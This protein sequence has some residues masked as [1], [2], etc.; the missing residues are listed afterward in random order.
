[1]KKYLLVCWIV[2]LPFLLV[3]QPKVIISELLY[4]PPYPNEGQHP[5]MHNGEF[6]SIYN[7]GHEA[8][9]VSGWRLV[10]DG[11]ASQFFTFPP[12]SIMEP[13]AKF[14]V[15]YRGSQTQN[16]VLSDLYEGFE[17]EANDR[18]WYHRAIILNNTGESLRL[19]REDGA[20][21]DSLWHSSAPM[22]ARNLVV[23]TPGNNC[24]SLQRTNVS[25]DVANGIISF[26]HSDWTA[27]KVALQ[28]YPHID[29]EL[30]ENGDPILAPP[31]STAHTFGYDLSGNRIRRTIRLSSPSS[32]PSHA[33]RPPE[34]N[35][36]EDEE[37]SELQDE[38]DFAF[39][40][41]ENFVFN[42]DDDD[43][44]MSSPETPD[45]DFV[46]E[47]IYTD[48]LN[49]SNVIIYPNPTKGALAVEIRNKNPQTQHQLT[50]LNF[51]GAVVFQRSD[52]ENYTQI[53]LSS[54]PKGVYFLRI[55]SQDRFI[56]W[57]IIKE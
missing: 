10:S 43:F 32:A 25:V 6:I 1:M 22:L 49:E 48:K 15:A 52:V 50:V 3:A 17:L 14:Y 57:K 45:N 44:P 28:E 37:K 11:G 55:S 23:G 9:D 38:N 19:Y 12:Q 41:E 24:L 20:T 18:K 36:E 16:F 51:N 56:T 29:R 21:Q 53:D 30:T 27:S 47:K 33:P 35:D 5:H 4:Q 13:K 34:N 39:I 54:Q 46:P 42:K 2:L 31:T 7:Y 26:N 8:V 40:D